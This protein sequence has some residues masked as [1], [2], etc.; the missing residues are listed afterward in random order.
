MNGNLESEKN[1]TKSKRSF[2]KIAQVVLEDE[3]QSG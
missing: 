3:L 2:R 1:E